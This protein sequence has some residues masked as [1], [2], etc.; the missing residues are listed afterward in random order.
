MTLQ[1]DFVEQISLGFA[2][3]RIRVSL[4]NLEMIPPTGKLDP[5]VTRILGKLCHLGQR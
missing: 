4:I 1:S 2:I 5:I 3:T